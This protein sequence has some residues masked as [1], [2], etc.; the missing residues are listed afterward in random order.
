MEAGSGLGHDERRTRSADVLVPN[1]DLVKPAAFDPTVASSLNQS[2]I[3]EV[4]VLGFPNKGSM[5]PK[6]LSAQS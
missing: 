6:M 3:N 1:W 5:P 2:I 4:C